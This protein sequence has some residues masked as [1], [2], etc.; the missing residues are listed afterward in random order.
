[1]RG[2]HRAYLTAAAAIVLVAAACGAD[3]EDVTATATDEPTDTAAD[4]PQ[5]APDAA[6]DASEPAAAPAP[7]D[8]GSEDAAGE[9]ADASEPSGS[10]PVEAGSVTAY[11]VGYHWGHAV[12]AEDGT[13]L[14][15]LEVPVGTEVELVAVNDHASE[16]I[17]RLPDAVVES[18]RATNW[19][20]RAHEDLE[21][22]HLADPE[23]EVGM[24]LSD[25][26]SAAHDGHDHTPPQRDHGLHEARR[27]AAGRDR[28]AAPGR[29]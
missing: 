20:D 5:P 27:A 26:I 10:T 11:V 15:V 25:A 17:S 19:H 9:V 14:D 13:E 8:E 12:F 1:M 7:P 2:S 23:L 6:D 16:A 18:I 21:A 29:G 3:A 4:D 28:G 24:S 22:G